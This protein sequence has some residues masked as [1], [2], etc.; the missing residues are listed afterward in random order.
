MSIKT[1]GK[2]GIYHCEAKQTAIAQLEEA[3]PAV[4][5]VK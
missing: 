4:E 3:K 1:K 5:S 2:K